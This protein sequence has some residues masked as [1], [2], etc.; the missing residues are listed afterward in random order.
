M[1]NIS[2][3]FINNH[4][5]LFFAHIRRTWQV[6]TVEIELLS[7]FFLFRW[8]DEWLAKLV[9]RW[10]ILITR[11]FEIEEKKH[12]DN[13]DVF[14]PN[15]YNNK[16]WQSSCFHIF[17]AVLSHSFDIFFQFYNHK[18]NMLPNSLLLLLPFQFWFWSAMMMS[19]NPWK[20]NS[21][22]SS[23]VLT[24]KITKYWANI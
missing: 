19:I 2:L 11:I 22:F 15:D 1:E 23:A 18:Y 12:L 9:S 5:F 10:G 16:V 21:V 20:G 8:L 13:C 14:F 17:M 7:G 4:L 3:H 24:K 6:N